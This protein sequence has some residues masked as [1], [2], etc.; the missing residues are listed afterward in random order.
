MIQTSGRLFGGRVPKV[1]AGLGDYFRDVYE[2]L[3]QIDRLIEGVLEM[4]TTAVQVNLGLINL[5][6]TEVTKKLAAW[7][8][9]IAVPTMIGGIYGMNFENMPE[10]KWT[11]GYPMALSAMV[12]LDL[13]LFFWFRRIQWL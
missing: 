9:M 8:A 2:H 5:N 13:G 11:F 4:L 10:L 3:A 7:G 12:I 1:A 6:A